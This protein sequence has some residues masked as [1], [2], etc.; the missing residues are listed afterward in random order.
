V[1]R[2]SL[3]GALAV[4]SLALGSAAPATAQL[5]PLT[6]PRG[7][8]RVELFGSVES[9]DRRL[10]LEA[11]EDNLGPIAADAQVSRTEGAIGV[12]LG[13][14]LRLTLL[15]HFPLVRAEAR[16][17]QLAPPDTDPTADRT[18]EQY[19]VTRGG[20][21]EL[22]LALGILDRWNG[23]A[24]RGVRLAVEGRVRLPT[25]Q[26]ALP[27][28]L[29]RIGTGDGQTDLEG[30]AALDVGAGTVGAR[31]QGTWVRQQPTS[32]VANA[33]DPRVPAEPESPLDRVRWDPGDVLRVGVRPYLRLAPALGLQL[34]LDWER[35]EADRFP[36]QGLADGE[37]ESRW[38]LS[39]GMSYANLG[40]L[41]PGGRGLPLDA[42][43]RWYHT[44]KQDVGYD[45]GGVLVRLRLYGRLF[46]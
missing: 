7:A 17:A 16:T 20:D 11:P 27:T 4:A 6:V 29:V 46:R 37:E 18:I 21:S 8:V 1:R 19:E 43:W 44:V 10:T 34:G 33:D 30:T 25:G 26:R 38:I 9:W 15:G 23:G 22:G 2:G 28:R 13:L 12:A 42:E 31:F 32:I 36:D 3:G 5:S 39:A 14:P 40:G 45:P 41:V 24:A 35:R